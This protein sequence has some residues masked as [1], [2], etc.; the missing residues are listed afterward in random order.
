MA[1]GPVIV[2]II[3]T[4]NDMTNII[5]IVW[6][7]K[8]QIANVKKKKKWGIPIRLFVAACNILF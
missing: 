2:D 4:N 1:C 8:K 6:R 3:V 7:M 5:K